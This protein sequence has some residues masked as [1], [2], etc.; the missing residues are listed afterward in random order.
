MEGS[1]RE[2][3]VAFSSVHR[4]GLR[5]LSICCAFSLDFTAGTIDWNRRARFFLAISHLRL[6]HAVQVFI[7]IYVSAQTA[8]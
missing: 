8:E 4:K 7:I 6:S 2:Q 1:L 3:P 5:K